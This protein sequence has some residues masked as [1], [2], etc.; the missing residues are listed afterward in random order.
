MSENSFRSLNTGKLNKDLETSMELNKLLRTRQDLT[1]RLR[2]VPNDI[3]VH[4]MYRATRLAKTAAHEATQEFYR[5]RHQQTI[6]SK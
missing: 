5:Q 4:G 3:D 2:Y 1:M 6:H